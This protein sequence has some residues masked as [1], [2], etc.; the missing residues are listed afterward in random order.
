MNH[1]IFD[2][3]LEANITFNSTAKVAL[4]GDGECLVKW[5]A[6]DGFIGEMTLRGQTWGAFPIYE[7]ANW[8]LE[9]YN[10]EDRL[11]TSYDNNV[12]DRFVLIIAHFPTKQP[13][14]LLDLSEFK[15][16]IKNIL[17]TYN[18]NLYVYFPES[19]KY[20]L[21]D[22]GIT[23]LRFNQNIKEFNLI[24]EKSFNG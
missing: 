9:F 15:V 10:E 2:K 23:P 24:L 19:E 8:R 12:T 14:K 17:E 7:I 18:C 16:Y 5:F 1:P 22:L 11:V 20:D 6:N 3:I 21:T 13:G 4:K